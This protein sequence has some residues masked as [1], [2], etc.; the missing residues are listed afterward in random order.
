MIWERKLVGIM[1]NSVATAYVR[2]ALLNLI[3]NNADINTDTLFYEMCSLFDLYNEES[4]S[5]EV[6]VRL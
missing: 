1:T 3:E 5:Q 4:I 2:I 6:L